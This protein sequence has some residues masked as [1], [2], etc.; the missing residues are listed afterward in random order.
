[1]LDAQRLMVL[2]EVRQEWISGAAGIPNR[3]CL[4]LSARAAGFAP[5]I[6]YETRDYQVTLALIKAGL[7]ISLVPA[8]VLGH[9]SHRG[10]AIRRFPGTV[11]ARDIYLLHRKRPTALVTSVITIITQLHPE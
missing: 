2:A 5:H 1:M 9:T 6:A 11:P 10:V 7:G 8:S 4:E 3:V